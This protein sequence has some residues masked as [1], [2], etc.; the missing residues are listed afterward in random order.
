MKK[1]LLAL[2]ALAFL[3]LA[4]PA[5]ADHRPTSY[6]SES[7]DVCAS[8]ERVDG[9]RKLRISLGA[10]YFDR[11]T[12]CVTAP[13]GARTCERFSIERQNGAFGDTVRWSR[14]FPN[15]GPGAYT[16]VWKDNK[17]FRSQRLGFH[18]NG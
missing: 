12:L 16:V 7:G 10:K 3:A 8:T 6:C 15:E 14:H 13:N 5:A 2:S 18:V 4:L 9:V 1:A 17:G 11:Y